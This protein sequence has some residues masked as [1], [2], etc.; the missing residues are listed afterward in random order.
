M[1]KVDNLRDQVLG[2]ETFV[3]VLE[4]NGIDVV[5]VDN[6][7][8]GGEELPFLAL[9]QRLHLLIIDTHNLVAVADDAVLD[10][11]AAAVHRHDGVGGEVAVLHEVVENLGLG[12]AA[13]DGAED[14]VRTEAL[15]VEG[16]VCGA[17]EAVAAALHIHNR[18]RRLRTD[19]RHL[20]GEVAVNHHIADNQY[21]SILEF[22]K[23]LIYDFLFHLLKN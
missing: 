7:L 23:N 10:G 2:K 9:F 6:L 1:R 17:A 14:R 4:D 16:H 12:V 19:A 21:L 5:V 8:H 20:A 11:G 22:L 3:V 13:D 15:E 18:N